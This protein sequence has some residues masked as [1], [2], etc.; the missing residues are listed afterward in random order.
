M[1]A[2]R[3]GV[4][5]SKST[6]RADS[7]SHLE[8]EA[9]RTRSNLINT[10]DE[11]GARVSPQAVKRD[12]TDYVRHSGRELWVNIAARARN[13]PL[14]TVAIATAV[15]YPVWRI[16]SNIP[17]PILLV[18]AGLALSKSGLELRSDSGGGGG[19]K[20]AFGSAAGG[21]TEVTQ[22]V[23]DGLHDAVSGAQE[24]ARQTGE[25]A[26][27]GIAGVA[28]TAASAASSGVE[29]IKRTI[30][31]TSGAV[32]DAVADASGTASS[33]LSSGYR[34]GVDATSRGGE[35]LIESGR[36]AQSSLVESIER[37][38]FVVGGI[39]LALGALIAASLPTT[40]VEDRFLGRSSDDLKNRATNYAS[41][42]LENAQ[43]AAREVYN[44]V[45][46]KAEEEGLTSDALR[47]S[48]KG[49]SEKVKT[50]IQHAMGSAGPENAAGGRAT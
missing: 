6:F 34:T 20:A 48:V 3:H 47:D 25:Q 2:E 50:V 32:G 45:T 14:Q 26:M 19:V 43:N 16:L 24:T 7:L 8:R 35:M 10:V 18:G 38:P 28:R 27:E 46:R 42:G 4:I 22:S 12:V 11:L 5:M 31:S 23:R 30:G 9:D 13:N 21:L 1:P 33:A 29:T 41:Q 36:R 40:R 15:A 39:G 17:V 44:E 49:A 37:H